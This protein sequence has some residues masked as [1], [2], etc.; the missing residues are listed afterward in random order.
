MA[1]DELLL[2]TIFA[3]TIGMVMVRCFGYQ[4]GLIFI[5]FIVG[6][7]SVLYALGSLLKKASK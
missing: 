4:I 3:L 1:K 6:G 2:T 7:S 5:A